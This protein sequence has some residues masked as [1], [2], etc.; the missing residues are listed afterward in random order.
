[1]RPKTTALAA[2]LFA[3]SI[4][5]AWPTRPAV[6]Q[7]AQPAHAIPQ[8]LRLEHEEALAQLDVLARR[9]APVGA[10]ARK[11]RDLVKRHQQREA[12]FI[13][14]PLTL[15]PALARGEVRPDMRWALEMATRVKAEHE[16]IFQEHTAITDG[17]N[18]LLTAAERVHD[19]AAIEIAHTLVADSLNDLELLEPTV[20]VIGE[21]LR[22]RLPANP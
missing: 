16:A 6:A 1:M 4:A 11:L 9:K 19:R 3:C 21:L 10:E 20:V 13:L 15:L 14:P 22:A 2:I 12:E 17:C 5:P 18:A 8:S 7:A